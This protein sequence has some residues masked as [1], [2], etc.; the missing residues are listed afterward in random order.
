MCIRDSLNIDDHILVAA[1]AAVQV[2]D[3][4][5]AQAE[6]GAALGAFGDMLHLSLIHI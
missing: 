6:L 2:L 3:A 5:A 1:A 4:L